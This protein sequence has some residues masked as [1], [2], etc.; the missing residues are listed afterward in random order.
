[1]VSLSASAP[2]ESRFSLVPRGNPSVYRTV[3][4]ANK[5][6]NEFEF[7][8]PGSVEK[9]Q[10][11]STRSQVFYVPAGN[12]R[13]VLVAKGKSSGNVYNLPPYEEGPAVIISITSRPS[14]GYT[15]ATMAVK[16]KAAE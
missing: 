4:I 5:T 1:M 3:T 6:S 12:T 14:E 16:P 10:V 8:L 7:M 15:I 2:T 11:D 9:H 13:Y